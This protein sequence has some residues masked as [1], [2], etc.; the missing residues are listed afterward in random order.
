M[1]EASS[2]DMGE[3]DVRHAESTIVRTESLAP[4]MQASWHGD[5]RADTLDDVLAG[6]AASFFWRALAQGR[7]A[8]PQELRCPIEV[9]SIV[10]YAALDQG[11]EAIAAIRQT[12]AETARS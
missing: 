6:R 3:H 9:A 4:G 5:A 12:A 7:P 8:K 1:V 11:A 2:G 10:N